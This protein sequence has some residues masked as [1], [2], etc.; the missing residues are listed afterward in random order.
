MGKSRRDWISDIE[1]LYT[2]TIQVTSTPLTEAAVYNTHV[3]NNNREHFS[4]ILEYTKEMVRSG[5][6]SSEEFSMLENGRADEFRRIIF[7]FYFTT[8]EIEKFPSRNKLSDAQIADVMN[9]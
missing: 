1:C 4:Y 5:V 8:K 2:N 9:N 3:L 7:H 6:V